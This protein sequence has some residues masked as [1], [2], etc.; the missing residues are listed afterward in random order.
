[1]TWNETIA[2]EASLGLR[3]EVREEVAL[4]RLEP[5]LAAVGH[6]PGAGV[7]AARR[8]AAPG[9]DGERLAA[10]A[11][12]VEH[13]AAALEPRAGSARCARAISSSVPR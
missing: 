12:E 3:G 10:A 11:A 9:E 6:H 8:H 2:A 5:P 1:M 4:L 7:D 13:G